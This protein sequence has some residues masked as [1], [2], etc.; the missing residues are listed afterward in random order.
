MNISLAKAQMKPNIHVMFP[1]LGLN[2]VITSWEVKLLPPQ[3]QP[4]I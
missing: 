1:L 2:T 3:L 4:Q